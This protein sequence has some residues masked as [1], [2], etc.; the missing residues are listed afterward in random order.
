MLKRKPKKTQRAKPRKSY[1]TRNQ[2]QRGLKQGQ[3]D[4]RK[5]DLALSSGSSKNPFSANLG[6]MVTRLT[7]GKKAK[8]VDAYQVIADALSALAGLN[9]GHL[10]GWRYVASVQSG[11]IIP[12]K[13]F[14][15]AFELYSKKV[16]P[17]HRQWHYF[18]KPRSVL[19][20]YANMMTAEIIR[21]HLTA[22]G[23]R[24]T[25]FSRYTQTKKNI[26]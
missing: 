22:M 8:K 26:Y 25:T 4:V 18:V 23:Y 5:H 12:G 3:N 17:H 19:S 1:K 13:K 11:T 20:F 10:W 21:A 9:N 15:R 24:A 2:D 14:I 16:K 6:Q 7:R